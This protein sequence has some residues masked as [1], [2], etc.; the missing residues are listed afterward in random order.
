MALESGMARRA[1][2]NGERGADGYRDASRGERLQR[3]MADA[4]IASRRDCERMI[5]KGLVEVNGTPVTDLPA[6]VDPQHDRIVVEGRV[7]PP[8]ARA[9]YILLQLRPH[10]QRASKCRGR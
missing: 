2:T 8:P 4:G 7:L 5:E 3:V 9:I 6:W 1:R 10:R